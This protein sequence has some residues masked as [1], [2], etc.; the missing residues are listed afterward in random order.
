MIDPPF[1][2][3]VGECSFKARWPASRGCYLVAKPA[4][5]PANIKIARVGDYYE[6]AISNVAPREYQVYPANSLDAQPWE[7]PALN[8]HG[9]WVM[10]LPS[11]PPF[12]DYKGERR[13][14]V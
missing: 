13:G 1:I 11:I 3:D 10:P 8:G 7:Y 14:F 4:I 9:L 12:G 6:A 2:I 5:D